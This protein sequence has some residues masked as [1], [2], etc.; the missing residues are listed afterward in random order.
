[1]ILGGNPK[2]TTA[3]SGLFLQM[4]AYRFHRM[5]VVCLPFKEAEAIKLVGNTFLMTKVLFANEI[6]ALCAKLGISYKD[7]Q[8]GIGLDVRI[9]TS[10]LSVPGHDS[11]FGAGGTCFP[12]DME[13]LRKAFKD[14]GV[15]ERILTAVALRNVEVRKEAG[16]MA[17]QPYL[18]ESV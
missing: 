4:D 6:F 16:L 15:P 5:N 14:N 13:N 10:H 3:V 18:P 11:K 9:G 1:M 2:D 8:A 7:V 12:K 17:G